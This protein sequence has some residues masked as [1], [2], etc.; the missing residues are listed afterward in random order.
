M[1]DEPARLRE[2]RGN[3]VPLLLTAG[4]VRIER[5]AEWPL[6]ML[7]V[8]RAIADPAAVIER[9][10]GYAAPRRPNHYAR[11]SKGDGFCLWFSPHRWL[12]RCDVGDPFAERLAH[13]MSDATAC[14]VNVTGSMLGVHLIGKGARGI[15]SQGCHLDLSSRAFPAGMGARTLFVFDAAVVLCGIVSPDSFTL[16]YDASL[17]APM[18]DWLAAAAIGN[19][20]LQSSSRNYNGT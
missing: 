7:A 12:V 11:S 20:D 18:T 10:V 15:L 13:G 17:D 9:A 4:D 3:G 6:W 14:A 19:R 8:S 16:Y 5:A 2:A 1:R